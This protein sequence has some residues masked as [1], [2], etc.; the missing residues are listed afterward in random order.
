MKYSLLV[1]ILIA[2][3]QLCQ[4]SAITYELNG[5]RLGDNLNTYCKAKWYAYK[6]K[7]PL[8]YKPFTYSD[9]LHLHIQET[10]FNANIF[11]EYEAVVTVNVEDDIKN[12]KNENVL[13]VTNFYTQAPGAYEQGFTHKEFGEELKKLLTPILAIEPLEKPYGC[14]TIALHVRKGGGF[15][16]PLASEQVFKKSIVYADQQWPTKFPPDQYYLDQLGMIRKILGPEKKFIIYLFTDDP[17]PAALA[18]RYQEHLTDTN[19]EFRFR[20]HD[21]SHD[22]HVVEDFYRMTQCDCLIRSSSLLARASQLIGNHKIIIHPIQGY[23]VDG[24]LVINPV[25][26]IIRN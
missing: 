14:I 10:L 12:H 1:F 11:N 7:L 22:A 3:A 19:V 26:I 15:D 25:G 21:N 5:G 8:L 20:A 2:H 24:T 18:Q 4:P 17:N 16:A 9:Q 23:W 6:Y 13:F